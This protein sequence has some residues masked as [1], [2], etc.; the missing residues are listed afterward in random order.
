VNQIEFRRPDN[1]S[2]FVGCHFSGLCAKLITL[3]NEVEQ[4][5]ISIEDEEIFNFP[6]KLHIINQFMVYTDIIEE[7]YYGGSKV[8]L[9]H[10]LNL[11]QNLQAILDTPHYL[12]VNKSVINS[13]NI[14][15]TDRTG[16]PIKFSDKLSNVLVK[17]HFRQ[18]Q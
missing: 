1:T 10:T 15:I 11:N 13:I 16:E 9:L 2:P 18:K 3:D 5:E 8:P 17:L 12:K 4:D 6:N 7:Q 14:R